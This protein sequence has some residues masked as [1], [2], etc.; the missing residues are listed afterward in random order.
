MSE[1]IFKNL[2]ELYLWQNNEF[3]TG[4]HAKFHQETYK[5][6]TGKQFMAWPNNDGR[7]DW[8][9]W[10][11]SQEEWEKLLEDKERVSVEE[12]IHHQ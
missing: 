3:S 7:T 6:T 9:E 10:G 11:L 12:S 8:K 4:G 1:T 2:F 5:E